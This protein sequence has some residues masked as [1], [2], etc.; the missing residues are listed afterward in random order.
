MCLLQK[1][2]RLIV[3]TVTVAT[4]THRGVLSISVNPHTFVDRPFKDSHSSLLQSPKS[5]LES[6]TVPLMIST[7]SL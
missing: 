1:M 6:V 2:L 5:L 4:D 7:W 3:V